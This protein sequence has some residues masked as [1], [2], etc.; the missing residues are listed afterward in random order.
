MPVLVELH[1]GSRSTLDGYIALAQHKAVDL[2]ALADLRASLRERVA[3][4]ALMDSER[5]ASGLTDAF[6]AM[7]QKHKGW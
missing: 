4:S 5:F 3:R 7:W 1:G 2:V 6:W